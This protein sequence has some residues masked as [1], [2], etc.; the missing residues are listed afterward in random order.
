MNHFQHAIDTNISRHG[1]HLQAVVGEPDFVH[2][3]GFSLFGM[4]EVICFGMPGRLIGPCINH[5]Y[6]ECVSGKRTPKPEILDEWFVLPLSCIE[7]TSDSIDTYAVQAFEYAKRKGLREMRFNQWVWTDK[8]GKFPWDSG[9]DESFR[10]R[11]PILGS[12][13]LL[14]GHG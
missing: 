6:S 8:E 11:Q 13:P 5:Y 1:I 10:H 7:V 2:S 12:P 9:F 4:P 3:V 14:I